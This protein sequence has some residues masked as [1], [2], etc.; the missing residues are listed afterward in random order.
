MMRLIREY[1][2][3]MEGEAAAETQAAEEERKQ[4][5]FAKKSF[6]L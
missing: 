4:I 5:D 1:K 2:P 6:F 3:D